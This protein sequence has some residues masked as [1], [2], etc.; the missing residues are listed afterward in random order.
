MGEGTQ[1]PGEGWDGERYLF[2]NVLSGDVRIRSGVAASGGSRGKE[3]GGGKKE[4]G[5]SA[6]KGSSS[7]QLL[8]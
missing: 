1:I 5:I 8:F 3:N 7:L 2:M 4:E 6:A